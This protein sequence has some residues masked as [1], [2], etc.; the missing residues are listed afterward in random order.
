VTGPTKT[1]VPSASEITI[2]ALVAVLIVVGKSLLR[3]PIGISGH[4]GV[5]WIGALVVGRA[6]VRRP[7][8]ATMMGFVGGVLVVLVQPSDAGLLLGVAKYALPGLV[9]DPLFPLLGRF[10]RLQPA[11]VAGATAHATKFAVDLVQGL[12]AGVPA[13]VLLA[14]ST[15]DLVAHVAFGALGGLLGALVLRGLAKANLPQLR[16]VAEG[17]DT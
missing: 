1:S 15:L 9:L 16:G 7:G 8:A 14:G 11:I 4:A 6:L 12:V 2:M 13:G 3:M 10:D 5:L 17:D